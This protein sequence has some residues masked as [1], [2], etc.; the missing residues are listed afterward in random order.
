MKIK[1]VAI[2]FGVDKHSFEQFLR[3]NYL[4]IL[5][6]GF[7]GITIDDSANVQE[8]IGEFKEYEQRIVEQKAHQSAA[9]AVERQKA[10][11]AAREKQEA[12]ANMLITSGF[13]FDGYTIVKY[14]GYISGDDAVQINRGT[15]GFF[16]S[17]TNVG[18]SLMKSLTK[19]RRNALKELKE[20]AYDLGCN[21]VIG[22]DFDYLTLEPETANSSG[23][24]TYLPYV[25]G[26]T[27]N[28]NA[29]IIEKNKG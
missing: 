26:V 21:A 29:V 20:A 28:G 5:K 14:S 10:A 22:V 3:N 25:F 6:D 15:A 11:Q 18:D 23:G 9:A 24:T 1:D 27:A 12:L 17:A 2:Q 8:L 13:N 19:I 4:S 16:S 7:M